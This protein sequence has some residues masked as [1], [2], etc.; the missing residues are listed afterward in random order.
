[1]KS[2]NSSVLPLQKPAGSKKA[3]GI[4]FKVLVWAFLIFL[5]LYA[6]LPMVW[7]FLSS[8][9]TNQELVA[10]PFSLPESF[11]FVN[12]KN[13]FAA[14]GLGRMLLNS[15]FIALVATT[16][17]VILAAMAAY[18]ISRFAFSGNRVI[19]VGL[20]A[21][22]LVPL[23]ALMLPYF[24]MISAVGLNNKLVGLILVYTAIGIPISTF[25]MVGFMKSV[26]KELEESA[27]M[28][29]AGFIGRFRHIIF[30]LSRTGIVTAA[31][32]QFLTCWNEFVYANLLTSSEKIRTIQVGIRYF[33]NQ[34]STDFVSMYAA[35]IISIVPSIVAYVVFQNQI[36]S[37]LTSG[38]VKG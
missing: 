16:L 12:Y 7:L 27:W 21:G 14:A 23:N 28:D 11:Q 1:M 8:L 26:P 38:A 17:N 33:T 36:I 4:I 3:L 2:A 25:I 15:V 22:I 6:L 9:K 18:A 20:S 29:G 37:G 19:Q 30:P 35:I 34:F 5:A 13:A 10:N 32:F 24:K 31:T